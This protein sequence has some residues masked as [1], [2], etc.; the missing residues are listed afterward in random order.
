MGTEVDFL[1]MTFVPSS[2][3]RDTKTMANIINPAP[4]NLDIVP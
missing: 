4:S 1:N 2:K 3:P